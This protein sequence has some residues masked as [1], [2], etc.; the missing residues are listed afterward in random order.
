MRD[1]DI[2]MSDNADVDIDDKLM[3]R[4][5]W[6]RVK[7]MWIDHLSDQVSRSYNW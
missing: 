1:Q 2:V 6:S 3:S 4:W 5:S 7:I